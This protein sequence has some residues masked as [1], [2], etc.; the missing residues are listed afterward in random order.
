MQI[1]RKNNGID[2]RG[3]RIYYSILLLATSVL[4][5]L[6][7]LLTPKIAF[8][9]VAVLPNE[10]RTDTFQ[11]FSLIVNS[12]RQV[13]TNRVRVM[14]PSEVTDIKPFVKE[15]WEVEV[16]KS[17]N[18]KG[19][20]TEIVWSGG[21]VPPGM[22]EE[23]M[24]GGELPSAEA[25]LKWN[26]YQTYDDGSTVSWDLEEE[27]QPK[28]PDGTFDVSR[29]GPYSKTLVINDL[30]TPEPKAVTASEMQTTNL[31]LILASLALIISGLAIGISLRQK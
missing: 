24:F 16:L 2:I 23:F 1:R 7:L 5:L 15:G 4:L 14:I 13:P 27:D 30:A 10:A 26:I 18:L 12:N 29:S 8:G 11:A 28:N 6:M 22:A 25:V 20:K 9:Q 21:S 19:V 31:P 17:D 3:F